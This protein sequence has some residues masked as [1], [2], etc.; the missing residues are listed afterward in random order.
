MNAPKL[1]RELHRNMAY[2]DVQAAQRCLWRGLPDGVSTNARNGNYG[3]QTARDVALFR[4]QVGISG[5]DDTIGGTLW[6]ALYDSIDSLGEQLFSHQPEACPS[7]GPQAKRLPLKEGM[8]PADDI[9]ACQRALW[10]ALQGASSN[11]RNGQYGDETVK[12]VKRFRQRYAI[13]IDDPGT[14]I[15]GDLYAVLTRWMDDTAVQLMQHYV[16]PTPAPAQ[17]LMEKVLQKAIT[18]VGYQEGSGNHTT[19]GEWYGLDNQPWCA[20]FVT[21]CAEA[22]NSSTFVRGSRYSYCP[23]V[24]DDARSKRHGLKAVSAG[25]VKRGGLALYD[26][27]GDGVSDHIGIVDDPPG[28]GTSFTTVEGNTSGGSSGSQSNGDGVYRRTRY[29]GDVVLFAHYE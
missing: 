11:A 15:G 6:P 28:S 27:G 9:K 14:K 1:W 8:G 21:W 24:V 26:W 18:Q 19:Y 4:D 17:G 12:D 20:M 25:S 2:D 22:L 10:R 16:P 23:S 13:N 5:D 29:L 3:E 7:P